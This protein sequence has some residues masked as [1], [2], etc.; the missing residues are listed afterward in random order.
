MQL[1]EARSK[2]DK[3]V[4]LLESVRAGK[5]GDQNRNP[6]PRRESNGQSSR[7]DHHTARASD[8]PATKLGATTA[9]PSVRSNKTAGGVS[10]S[11]PKSPAKVPGKT[12]AKEKSSKRSSGA[13]L[14]VR[15]LGPH[16]LLKFM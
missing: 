1:A 8:S 9:S 4:T 6:T 16:N 13:C 2:L 10:A 11:H 3:A 12:P 7:E 5:L 14:F 15:N